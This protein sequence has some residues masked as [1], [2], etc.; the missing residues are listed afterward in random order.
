MPA[1]ARA[2]VREL[3]C[4][5]SSVVE[6]IHTALKQKSEQDP[7]LSLS[8]LCADRAGQDNQRRFCEK[9]TSGEAPAALI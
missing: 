5:R 9:A 7:E 1:A 8:L 4:D 6:P 3:L 2:Q